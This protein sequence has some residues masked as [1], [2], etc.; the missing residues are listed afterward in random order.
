MSQPDPRISEL[1]ALARVEGITL[2][3]PLDLIVYFE[4]M[5][6]VVD[7]VDG[8]VCRGVTATPT[9]HA[10]AVAHLLGEVEGELVIT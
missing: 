8:T 5:G 2:P 10:R 6:Y 4:R 3:L 1:Q 9:V 7:L